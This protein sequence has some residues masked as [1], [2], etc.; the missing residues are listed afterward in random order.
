MTFVE[1]GNPSRKT[2]ENGKEA[3]NFTKQKYYYYS[4]SF[5]SKEWGTNVNF[6]IDNRIINDILSFNPLDEEGR[7]INPLKMSRE[8]E[9][10]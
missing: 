3:I 4:V 2:L 8:C 9:N 1:D 7:E 5:L 6:N 10:D